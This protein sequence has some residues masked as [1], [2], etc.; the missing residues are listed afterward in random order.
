MWTKGFLSAKQ[1]RQQGIFQNVMA[2]LA[3]EEHHSYRRWL[4][5]D[6]KCFEELVY[7]TAQQKQDTHFREC[8]SPSERLAVSLRFIATGN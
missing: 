5:L 6:V 3:L 8:I 7:L 1:R 4:R 2:E